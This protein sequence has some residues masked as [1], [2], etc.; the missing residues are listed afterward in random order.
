[1]GQYLPDT[2]GYGITGLK[3]GEAAFELVGGN[4]DGHAT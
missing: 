1:M 4:E 3:C 2:A